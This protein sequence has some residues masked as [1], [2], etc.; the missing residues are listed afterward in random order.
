MVRPTANFASDG[1]LIE[2]RTVDRAWVIVSVLGLGALGGL[3][4]VSGRALHSAS[5]KRWPDRAELHLLAPPAAGPTVR[6]MLDP[7]HGARDNTGNRSAFCR[8]EQDFTLDLSR[9]IKVALEETGRFDVIVSRSEGEL[10]EYRDRLAE[11]ESF[12]A[13]AFVSLHS[14]VR[15]HAENWRPIAGRD[16]PRHHGGNGF[17]VLLSDEVPEGL[18]RRRL[19]ATSVAREV[20]LAGFSPYTG[21]EYASDYTPLGETPGV[22][23]DRH[24]PAERIFVLRSSAVPAIIVETHNAIDDRE[25]LLWEDS[26]TR[27]AFGRAL[28]RA[29]VAALS[30]SK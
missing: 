14:D 30:G 18:Q 9:D 15:G 16:C 11:A 24:A 5:D 25:A 23:A 8:D 10:V 1:W 20:A 29:L 21:A 3:G 27:H 22:F 17:A 7:G 2:N 4:W 13:Q 12:G 19:L 6:L 28:A 26:E